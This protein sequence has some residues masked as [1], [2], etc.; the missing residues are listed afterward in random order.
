MN[1]TMNKPADSAPVA[2]RGL[3][4]RL[5]DVLER[6][7]ADLRGNTHDRF[8]EYIRQKDLLL[9]DISRLQ[10]QAFGQGGSPSG[11]DEIMHRLR[12]ALHDNSEALKLHLETAREFAGSLEDIIRRH[13]SDGTYGRGG[14]RAGYGRW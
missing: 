3:L 5:V 6:E 4:E 1:A 7:T 2:L 10:E 8:A 12:A 9:L 14:G 13:Q 11:L